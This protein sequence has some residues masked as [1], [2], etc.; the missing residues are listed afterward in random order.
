M[1][2]HTDRTPCHGPHASWWDDQ[3][4]LPSGERPPARAARHAKAIQVCRTCPV[5]TQCLDDRLHGG[6]RRGGVHGGQVFAEGAVLPEPAPATPWGLGKPP[7][8][9]HGARSCSYRCQRAA[10]NA[11][12]RERR[13][14]HR[15]VAA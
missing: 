10:E 2:R 9:R 6:D 7:G 15:G 5:M 11:R 13:A 1:T 3:L 8:L 4:D 12:R 14:A